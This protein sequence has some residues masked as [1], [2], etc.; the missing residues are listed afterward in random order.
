[1]K[2]GCSSLLYGGYDVDTA[3]AWLQAVGYEAIELCAIPGMGEHFKGGEPAE[4]YAALRSK[5]DA[6]GLYL[7]SVG[8]SGALGT[9][10]FGPLLQAAAALGAPT[11]TCLLY[12]SPSPRD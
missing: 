8:C 2:L 12:T 1:M 10:R 11:M 6:A 9:D 3:I 5:L 7:D 4:V